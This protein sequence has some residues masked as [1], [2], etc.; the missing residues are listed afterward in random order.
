M[1]HHNAGEVVRIF[2]STL[3]TSTPIALPYFPN[4]SQTHRITIPILHS[5]LPHATPPPQISQTSLPGLFLFF[6]VKT[7]S[8]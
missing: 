5:S 6:N 4:L 1:A 8:V 2:P 7:F 3:H